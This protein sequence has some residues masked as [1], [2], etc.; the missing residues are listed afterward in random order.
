MENKYLLS[1]IREKTYRK[2][3]F[4]FFP[5]Q[6]PEFYNFTAKKSIFWRIKQERYEIFENKRKFRGFFSIIMDIEAN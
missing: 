1:K 2:L 6:N 4:C 5:L 3:C